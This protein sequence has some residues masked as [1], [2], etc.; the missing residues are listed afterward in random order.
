MKLLI[1]ADPLSSLNPK[2]DTGLS[3]AR[4]ALRRDFAVFWSTPSE[5]FLEDSRV[6]FFG[7]T[8]QD[9]KPREW[10]R[11]E[12]LVDP[13]PGEEIDYILV[14]KDPPFD[15]NYL[16][17]CWK[18]R[19]I[20][21][22]SKVINP[23]QSLLNFHEKLIPNLA[24][25]EGFLDSS[26]LLPSFVGEASLAGFLSDLDPK[27]GSPFIAKPW[28]GHGGRDIHLL[29]DEFS[30]SNV[31]SKLD[32]EIIAQ[33]FVAE[34][35]ELG[36]RRVF[37]VDGKHL[38]DFVRIP[39]KSSIVANLS[40]GGRAEFRPISERLQKAINGLG[41][42]LKQEN[43][44]LAGADFIGEYLTEVNI[45]APTG[46]ETLKDLGGKDLAVEFFDRLK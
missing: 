39:E 6:F 42:F 41:A 46:F 45:T 5:V 29:K 28:L 18:L 35:S 16:S 11:S 25:L 2:S 20:A 36:D 44:H 34:I 8:I 37:Y 24:V 10:P 38:G 21:P 27:I 22:T 17:L 1:V 26:H 43:I 30:S 31:D 33:K 7:D 13:V 9:C 14:R 12:S 3:L 40:R 32:E 23:V 4:E 19:L 15:E